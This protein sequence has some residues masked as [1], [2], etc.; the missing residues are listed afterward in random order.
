MTTVPAIRPIG[1]QIDADPSAGGG[2]RAEGTGA[3]TAD[4]HAATPCAAGSAIQASPLA[5]SVGV[6]ICVDA[7]AT[8]VVRGRA[9]ALESALTVTAD[10]G[11]STGVA[12]LAAVETIRG[13][14]DTV[15]VTC[16]G[17]CPLVAGARAM[18]AHAAAARAAAVAVETHALAASAR[19]GVGADATAV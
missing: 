10:L 15:A 4:A 13:Q 17:T 3:R 1:G 9:T 5:A 6:G 18:D 12:A 14:I 7:T 19:I 8:A 16:L 11:G 2:P